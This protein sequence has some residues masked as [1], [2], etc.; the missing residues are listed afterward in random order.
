MRS[1]NNRD[2]GLILFE[3]LNWKYKT[4]IYVEPST[5][6]IFRAYNTSSLDWWWK[7]HLAFIDK[8]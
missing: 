1:K 7:P 4:I 6:Y 2:K 8:C 5:K 3:N